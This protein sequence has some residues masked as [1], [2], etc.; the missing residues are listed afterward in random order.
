MR[1]PAA[2][3]KLVVALLIAVS[4]AFL[5]F[6]IIDEAPTVLDK[7]DVR[8]LE[9]KDGHVVFNHVDFSCVKGRKILRDNTFE[10]L[11]GQKIGRCGPTGAGKST[12][13]NI[14]TRYYDIDSGT[15]TIDGQN[16][17]DCTQA[18]L[19]AD[20]SAVLQ[21][22]FL[23]TDTVMNNLKYAREGATDEESSPRPRKPTPTTSLCSCR[24][25]T[26]RCGPSAAPT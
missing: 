24:A 26:T 10:A 1:W 23:F 9:L 4:G 2:L 12:I 16:I 17:A 18:S 5:L 13:I 25:S 14:L 3:V 6:G 15:I 11:P 21:E 7:P 22:P 8:L 19:R 20:I